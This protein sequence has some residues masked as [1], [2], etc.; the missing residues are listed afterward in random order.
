MVDIPTERSIQRAIIATIRLQYPGVWY[1]AIPNGA[2][3]AGNAQARFKQ[4]G[5]LKG[6]GLKIGAPD[7][8]CVWQG[9]GK[10]LEVKRPKTGRVSEDQHKV[11]AYLESVGWPVAVVRTVEEACAALDEAG[12]PRIGEAA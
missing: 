4:I 11:H 9:G 1:C 12:A 7:L 2:H 8:I 3:L 10:F 6:D 5:A